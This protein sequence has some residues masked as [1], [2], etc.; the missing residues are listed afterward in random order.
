MP[1]PSRIL[2]GLRPILTDPDVWLLWLGLQVPSLRALYKYLPA[3]LHPLIVIYLLAAFGVYAD[4]LHG[5]WLKRR[6][7]RIL[8]SGWTMICLV[9]VAL[10]VNYV[11]YPIAYALKYQM[12]G[13]DQDDALILVGNRLRHLV[14]PYAER[15]YYNNPISTGPGLVLLLLPFLSFERYFLI[16][17]LVLAAVAYILYRISGSFYPA[18][19][20]IG[21]CLTSPA[22]WETIVAG[23]DLFVIGGLLVL[24][25]ALLYAKIE[26]NRLYLF[27]G[28]L[29][30]VLAVTSRVVFLYLVPLIG[31]FLWK[32]RPSLGY[33]VVI[34]A[35]SGALLIH[36]I[37]YF[38]DPPNYTPLHLL[39]KG[40]VLLP[41]YLKISLILSA[42]AV[43]W[44]TLTKV[45]DNLVSWL[46]F[47]W[48][49]LVTPLAF[50]AFGDL[51]YRRNFQFADWEGAN[52][53][54]VPLAALVSYIVLKK[55]VEP[56]PK[57]AHRSEP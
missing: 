32:R 13:S 56:L 37:F 39:G 10:G 17:P 23:S 20:F 33:T 1:H 2:A 5:G 21:L 7:Q 16:T 34:F 24:C 35:L 29:F 53:L 4:F 14:S 55:S 30:L 22:F 12:R 41:G 28:I 31:L 11:V 19:L 45:T 54:L 43:G 44:L 36:G 51:V 27:F 18:N 3:R 6:L 52:Y 15:T 50:T 38:W 40:G 25:L 26:Q 42:L 47:L 8:S 57:S 48:L 9:A 49:G 46:F